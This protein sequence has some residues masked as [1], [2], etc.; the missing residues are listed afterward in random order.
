[1]DFNKL[2][3]EAI[4][5][6]LRIALRTTYDGENLLYTDPKFIKAAQRALEKME[7]R[8]MELCKDDLHLFILYD[9]Y[10]DM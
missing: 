4:I 2:E 6:A 1:M 10:K 5:I 8:Y 3:I 7:K 9:S